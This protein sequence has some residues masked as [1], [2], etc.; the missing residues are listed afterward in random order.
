MKCVGDNTSGLK[1][2]SLMKGEPQDKIE[3]IHIKKE[4]DH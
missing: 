2:K 3:K 4:S 1:S